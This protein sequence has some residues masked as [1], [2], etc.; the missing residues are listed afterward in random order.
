MVI[1]HSTSGVGRIS[2][3]DSGRD[4]GKTFCTCCTKY[5]PG[6]QVEQFFRRGSVVVEN[7]GSPN[8]SGGSVGK[9]GFNNVPGIFFQLGQ[10]ECVSKSFHFENFLLCC[11][12]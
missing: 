5:P 4:H 12:M 1:H 11:K 7:G 9:K 8:V 10:G 2:V 3:W 6:L